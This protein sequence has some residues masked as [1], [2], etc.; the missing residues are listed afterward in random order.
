MNL[1]YDKDGVDVI[2][3]PVNGPDGLGLNIDFNVAERA[4]YEMD[5]RS[6]DWDLRLMDGRKHI[7]TAKF[8][9]YQFLAEG[10]DRRTIALKNLTLEPRARGQG[11]SYD[12][13]KFVL[14][15]V[16]RE[17]DREWGKV[18]GGPV[19]FVEKRLLDAPEKER[20][21]LFDF[22]KKI[23][24]KVVGRDSIGQP[25]GNDLA[26]SVIG[27]NVSMQLIQGHLVRSAKA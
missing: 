8:S 12:L 10:V 16:T 24:E 9:A 17:C 27:D 25:N 7:G 3:A 21:G 18:Y 20:G 23:A 11:K 26:V 5:H 15:T 14:E 13:M 6:R 19:V 22:L 4:I 2:I 1:I